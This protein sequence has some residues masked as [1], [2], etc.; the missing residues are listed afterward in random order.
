[1][2]KPS[3]TA[4]PAAT[5]PAIDARKL[6][7]ANWVMQQTPTDMHPIELHS[8]GSDAG[9]RRYFRYQNPS[10]WLAV[11]AP[12]VTEDTTQ[13]LAIAH[14]M[15]QHGVRSPNIAAA[16]ASQGFLLV[17]D[18]GDRLF[19]REANNQNADELYQQAMNTLLKLHHSLDDT[20][21]IPRYDRA[22]LRRELEIFS[23]W[24]VGKLLDHPLTATEQR[25][26]NELFTHLE[27]NALAQP[28][29]FV[30]RDYH[31]R[32]LLLLD[33]GSLGVIDFQGALWGAVTYDLVSLLRDCYLRWPAE[34]V[35]GW[36]LDYRQQAINTGIINAVSKEEFLRWFD[37]LG[38][39]RHIKVL[40]I[41]ARLAL[42]DD[43]I[44]YLNDLPL[45]IRY[46]LEVAEQYPELRPFADW[47]KHTLLPLAQQQS[48]YQDYLTAGSQTAGDQ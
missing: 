22:L 40:G 34:K 29:T 14:F 17:E 39:Q 9:F 20:A 36:A 38:L 11:D 46:T 27:D 4:I 26:L 8:L 19:F 18:F 48:W 2:T 32:N 16:D 28:Q 43:K 35:K 12:P 13:F 24:F 37:W 30:H 21:L 45:V 1:M 25:L 41:F 6:A 15:E 42:R 47:F 33:D 7:L 3:I 23:E 31:S 10:Q 44:G 5:Q